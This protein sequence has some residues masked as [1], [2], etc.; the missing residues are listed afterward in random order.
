VGDIYGIHIGAPVDGFYPPPTR[1][2]LVFCSVLLNR[3]VLTL[4]TGQR[5]IGRIDQWLIIPISKL[6]LSYVI[7][8][9]NKSSKQNNHKTIKLFCFIGDI[10]TICKQIDQ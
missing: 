5:L 6:L 4:L 1:S 9:S 10:V 7:Q 2:V 8:S 3:S